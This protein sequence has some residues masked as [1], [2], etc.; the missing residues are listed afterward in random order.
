[1]QLKS[2]RVGGSH[3]LFDADTLPEPREEMFEPD[4]WRREG[5]VVGQG[6]GR[7][8][9]L[10]VRA[11]TETWVLRHYRRGGLAAK[12]FGDRY[13]TLS[14]ESSRPWREL[15]LT[16]TLHAQ[17]LPV[18]AP[19]AARVNGTR[20]LRKGDLITRLI[21]DTRTLADCL[22]KAP[23]AA[24]QWPELGRMLRRFHDAGLLHH[25]INARNILLDAAGRFY[26]IDLDKA[27]LAPPGAWQERTRLRLLRSLR[28]FA[29][30]ERVFHFSGADWDALTAAYRQPQS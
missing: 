22:T 11:G 19:V 14:F 7:G 26:L 23:L 27:R 30:K 20:P 6:D 28:K 5:A 17:G 16:A 29:D 1:M 15:R 12:V 18:P 25:D 4:Y 2:A 3:I 21:R 9:A 10:F 8:E 24:G 13:V